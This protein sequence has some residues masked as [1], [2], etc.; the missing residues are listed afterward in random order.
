MEW[1]TIE[2][3][4]R[5]LAERARFSDCHDCELLIDVVKELLEV[6]RPIL[7]T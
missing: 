6:L 3:V 1:G 2:H 7:P 5:Q 4:E